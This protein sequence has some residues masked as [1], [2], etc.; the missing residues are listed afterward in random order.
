MGVYG[1]RSWEVAFITRG[2]NDDGE[3]QLRLSPKARFTTPEAPRKRPIP[4]GLRP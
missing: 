4:A 1:I 3:P 2:T